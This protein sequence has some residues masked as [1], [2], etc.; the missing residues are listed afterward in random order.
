MANKIHLLDLPKASC[1]LLSALLLLLITAGCGGKLFLGTYPNCRDS[2]QC[3]PGEICVDNLCT[4]QGDGG[5]T[6]GGPPADGGLD[7][8][9]FSDGGPGD[10]GPGDGGPGDGGLTDGGIIIV[11]GGPDG[12]LDGGC[13]SLGD[14]CSI[15]TECCHQVCIQTTSLGSVCTK[16]CNLDCPEGWGCR[17]IQIGTGYIFVCFPENDIYCRPCNSS[18]ECGEAGDHC[19]YIVDGYYCLKGCPSQTCPAAYSCQDATDKE[20]FATKSCFPNVGNCQP[21]EPVTCSQLGKQ[22]GTWSDGCLGTLTCGPC[23]YPDRSTCDLNGQCQCVP[24]SCESANK[25]CGKWDDGCG[26]EMDCNTCPFPSISTCNAEGKCIYRC[27]DGYH[28]C[29]TSQDTDGGISCYL[30]DDVHHCGDDVACVDCPNPVHGTPLCLNDKCSWQCDGFYHKNPALTE[31]AAGNE[32]NCCLQNDTDNCCGEACQTCPSAG[33][34]TKGICKATGNPQAPWSCGYACEQGWVDYDGNFVN[35]CECQFISDTD[36]PGDGID[37]N[38]DGVDGTIGASIFVSKTGDDNN[39]GTSGN[40]VATIKKGLA[41]AQTTGKAYVLVSGDLYNENVVLIEGINLLGGYSYD[42]I[43]RDTTNNKTFIVGDTLQSGQYGAV[44]AVNIRSVPTEFSGFRVNGHQADG[45]GEST[46]SVYVRNCND[47][48]IIQ[49]NLIDGANAGDGK[50]GINGSTGHDGTGGGNGADVKE[51]GTTNHACGGSGFAALASYTGNSTTWRQVTIDLNAYINSGPIQL[52]FR[53]DTDWGS[54]EAG[55]NIDDVVVKK[56]STTLFTENFSSTPSRWTLQGNWE[57]DTRTY[58]TSP[59]SLADSPNNADYGNNWDYSAT[60][61]QTFDLSGATSAQ[62]TFWHRYEFEEDYDYGF[63]EI[64]ASGG[65]TNP[66]GAGGTNA[67]CSTVAG[68]GG[69]AAT[70][71][72]GFNE[73]EPAGA[74]GGN[75]GGLGGLGGYNG[76]IP[77]GNC[78]TCRTPSNGAMEGESGADGTKGTDGNGGSGAASVGAISSSTWQWQLTTA[79]NGTTGAQGRGGGG[80]GAGGGVDYTDCDEPDIFGGGGGGGGAGGCRGT[81]GTAGTSGGASI[82]I[83]VVFTSTPSQTSHVPTIRDNDIVPGAGGD[84]GNG[85]AG[86]AGGA[87]GSG[88]KG[89]EQQPTINWCAS[90]GGDGGSGGRGGHGGGGGGGAGG[91]SYGIY[92]HNRGSV[93]LSSYKSANTYSTDSGSRGGL[94]GQGGAGGYVGNKGGNG[95]AGVLADTNLP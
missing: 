88:G 45:I 25:E 50:D 82:G 85:G 68:G 38:C 37:Q 24:Q 95:A 83:L 9:G 2:E 19:V 90:G 32:A 72:V 22:C 27:Q 79:T 42:F 74:R 40:P 60:I 4:A 76:T 91:A 18:Y 12:G 34:H 17:G 15:N 59:R 56:G 28:S 5:L 84:G 20:G 57:R 48:L 94:R 30:D 89:G 21:C 75:S 58:H 47:S 8:G 3:N 77:S 31:C 67:N 62:L 92:V 65:S 53:I 64:K 80:G 63:V 7:D 49:N 29:G 78:S 70:C 66:G 6:D 54:R 61:T 51:A 13:G 81:L 10:G 71:P 33:P 52:R 11:D 41:L 46:Y 55:W 26:G 14:R 73:R 39:N 93:N 87:G 16:P 1:L 44:T 35:G 86:G 69:G 43:I 23:P 36:L